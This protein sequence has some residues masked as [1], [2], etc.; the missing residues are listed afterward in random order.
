MLAISATNNTEF[1]TETIAG[2]PTNQDNLFTQE[3][4]FTNPELSYNSIQIGCVCDGHGDHGHH[5]SKTVV[6]HSQDRINSV[7]TPESALTEDQIKTF[8]E[9]LFV[10]IQSEVITM[11]EKMCETK[12]QPDGIVYDKL[13]RP[14]RGGSSCVFAITIKYKNGRKKIITFHIGD[15]LAMVCNFKSQTRLLPSY[16][17]LTE[18]HDCDSKEEYDRIMDS[19]LSH[20]FHFTYSND[21]R[22]LVFDPI[23]RKP[24]LAY[25]QYPVKYGIGRSSVRSLAT[26]ARTPYGCNPEYCIAMTRSFGNLGSEKYGMSRIP[27]MNEFEL[28]DNESCD[29]F[30]ASDGYFDAFQFEDLNNIITKFSTKSERVE[31]LES[32]VKIQFGKFVDDRT[33]ITWKV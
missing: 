9:Q 3:I 30:V 20:P 16:K 33:F 6:V 10:S 24:N 12:V 21:P 15:S 13:G 28:E 7:L 29:V 8:F 18:E 23:T 11:F 31:K 26:Y 4:N 14:C 2:N 17:L 19:G 1:Q 27:D 5:V 32:E 22:L 25:K